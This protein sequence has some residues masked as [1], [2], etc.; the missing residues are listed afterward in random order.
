MSIKLFYGRYFLIYSLILYSD[1]GY[2]KKSIY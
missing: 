2:I 1:K